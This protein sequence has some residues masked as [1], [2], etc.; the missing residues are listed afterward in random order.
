MSGDTGTRNRMLAF[1]AAIAGAAALY[2]SY[3]VTMPLAVAAFLVATLWPVKQWFDHSLPR[4][5]YLGTSLIL[6]MV[7]AAFFTALYF[8][9]AQ[10]GQAF[11][12]NWDQLE[13]LYQRAT[14]WLSRWGIRGVGVQ[15][16]SRWIG[17]GQDMLS[18]ASTVLAY[19][20]FIALLFMLGLPEVARLK[21]RLG[22]ELGEAEGREIT[23]ITEEIAHRLRQY[24]AVTLL[25]SVLTGIASTLW[26][27]AIGLELP[28]VWG[29]LNFLLNFIPVIG[30]LLGIVPPTLYALIQFQDLTWP[31]V[32]FVGFSVIQIV[33]S[34]FVYP[35]LQG[36]SLSLSPLAVVVALGFWSSVWGFAGALMAIPLTVTLVVICGRIEVTR[37][38][39]VLLSNRENQ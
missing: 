23:N 30:N 29:T 9:V 11:S 4:L 38:I 34:N 17:F 16:R 39:S 2:E 24:L 36:R 25:T 22:E 3:P 12:D 20:G 33:I 13:N 32:A 19:L 5:S 14:D 37:W 27:F 28:L 21:R 35:L 7:L 8:C 15:D 6:L 18:Q 31:L 1:I 10:V 26:A